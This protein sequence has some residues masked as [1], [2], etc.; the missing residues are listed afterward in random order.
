[1]NADS[2]HS[3]RDRRV[4]EAIAAYL[5]E[6]DAGRPPDR[7]AFLACH[8]DIAG[9][10]AAFFADR[11]CF[12]RAAAPLGGGEP[13][14]LAPEPRSVSGVTSAQAPTAP[15][16]SSLGTVRYFG[17]YELLEEI[18]RGG[19]GVVYKARQVSLE[20]IVA[21]KMILAGQLASP[22][23]VQRFHTEA[24]AAANLKH[25]N[26]VAIHEVGVHEGQH[27]FSMD[28]IA[29][30]SLAAIIR[31][32]PLPATRAARYVQM[33]AEAIEHA[34]RQGTLHRDLK[35]SNV[36]IDE[37]DRPHVTDFGLAKQIKGDAGLTGTGQILG[38]PSYM[39]PEQAA[40]RPTELGPASDVYALGAVLY[41]LLTGR[42]PFRAESV[43][44]TIMQVVQVEPVPPRLLNP[45]VPREL[46]TICLKCLEKDPKKRFAS[47]QD[48]A[49]DLGRFL[50]GEPI[51]AR[52]PSMPFVVRHWFRQNLRATLWTCGIGLAAGLVMA[53]PTFFTMMSRAIP[54]EPQFTVVHSVWFTPPWAMGTSHDPVLQSSHLALPMAFALTSIFLI[55]V[56]GAFQGLLAGM[57]AQPANRAGDIAVGA[58]SGLVAGLAFFVLA[59]GPKLN[60]EANLRSHRDLLLLQQAVATAFAGPAANASDPILEAYPQ[61]GAGSPAQR[62][63]QLRV[64]IENDLAA[65]G[66]QGLWL[67]V[68]LALLPVPL[69]VIMALAGGA[70]ARRQGSVASALLGHDDTVQLISFAAFLL[71]TVLLG[72]LALLGMSPNKP[73]WL[74]LNTLPLFVASWIEGR[75]RKLFDEFIW[76]RHPFLTTGLVLSICV[77]LVRFVVDLAG[78][79]SGENPVLALECPWPWYVDALLYTLTMIALIRYWARRQPPSAV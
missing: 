12:Q 6:C 37:A 53:L 41:E 76:R 4:N 77:G 47:A 56:P 28:Y 58:A 69:G 39:P 7:A 65:N 71:L 34:H 44:D 73:W 22:A 25:P 79:L 18:A 50:A 26:I 60:V 1:M 66:V 59:L 29:G 67:A 21:L 49:D 5:A 14:T 19:M 43:F 23:D 9:E 30:R 24:K 48:L 13:P 40:G 8:S 63:E 74:L 72:L 52:P 11:D 75:H 3:S 10:L 15:L 36:L 57:L 68:G 33:I 70:V 16:G 64:K 61:W 35:P 45:T 2:S 20:R 38:T 51:R 62:S 17:D 78:F 54:G 31:D 55:M 32:N 42:P 46:D 27:F